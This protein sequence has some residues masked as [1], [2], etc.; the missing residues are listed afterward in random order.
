MSACVV[1]QSFELKTSAS[2]RTACV[3]LARL[4]PRDP[5]RNEPKPGVPPNRFS[6]KGIGLTVAMAANCAAR[7]DEEVTPCA[8]KARRISSSLPAAVYQSV[9]DLGSERL[10]GIITSRDASRLWAT[11]PM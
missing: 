11:R 8:A 1:V 2:Q 4:A 5:H 3:A 10:F 9:P 7:G 6:K